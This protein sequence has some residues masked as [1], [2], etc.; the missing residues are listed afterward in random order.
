MAEELGVSPNDYE[1]QMLYG[2]AEPIARAFADRG[3]LVRLYVPIGDLLPGM[4]Y[5]VRRLLEN[6]SNESFLRHTFV[7]GQE[8]DEL[9]RA[10][11]TQTS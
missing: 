9:L 11:R 3:Y 10:P 5:L 8:V 6:T 1:L 2:M 7:E 4:G